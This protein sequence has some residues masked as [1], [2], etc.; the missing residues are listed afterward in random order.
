M[1]CDLLKKD[2][3]LRKKLE[4]RTSTSMSIYL[5]PEKALEVNISERVRFVCIYCYE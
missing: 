1:A 3:S 2:A 4:D 5:E